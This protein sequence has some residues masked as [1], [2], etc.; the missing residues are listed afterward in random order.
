[1]GRNVVKVMVIFCFS[2]SG[3]MAQNMSGR[4]RVRTLKKRNKTSYTVSFKEKAAL[5]HSKKKFYKCLSSSAKSGK[6]ILVRW[7]MK[8]LE[9]NGCKKFP[10]SK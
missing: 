8:T 10:V 3:V 6:E 2:F 4:L 5:Y 7:N 9:V 1:M